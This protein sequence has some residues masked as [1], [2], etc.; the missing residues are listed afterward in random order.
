MP[1]P[2]PIKPLWDNP[3]K[4]VV[5]FEAWVEAMGHYFLLARRR[6]AQGVAV[7]FDEAEKRALALIIGG[8]EIK[9]LFETVA[10]QVIAGDNAVTF[11]VA[12]TASRAALRGRLNETSLVYTLNKMEQGSQAFAAWYPKVMEAAKRIDW[13]NYNLETACKNVLIFNCESDKLR[14]KAIAENL[15]YNDFIRAGIA[16]ENSATK[17]K[18]MGAEGVKSV[19]DEEV[20]RLEDREKKE[21]K[22]CK[23]CGRVA[24]QRGQTCFALK[25]TCHQ[26]SKVGHLK[27]VCRKKKPERVKYLSNSSEGTEEEPVRRVKKKKKKKKKTVPQTDSDSDESVSKINEIQSVKHGE[28]AKEGPWTSLKVNDKEVGFTIDSGVKRNLLNRKDW[29]R[30]AGTTTATQTNKRF[31]PYGM[32]TQL[33][34]HSKATVSLQAKNGAKV[35][36]EVF[37]VESE[38]VD[39]LLG[40]DDGIRLGIIKLCP[41]GQKRAKQIEKEVQQKKNEIAWLRLAKKIE[42][43]EGE[44]FS[45]GRCQ[46]EV[47]HDIQVILARHSQ[48]FQGLGRVKKQEVDIQLK[49]DA[50]PKIQPRR[51]I[52]IH[53]MDKLKKKVEELKREGVIEGPLQGPLEPGSYVSNPV[54]TAKRWSS[55]EIRLNL[56]LSDANA[57]I[58]MSAHPI[59]TPEELRHEFREADTFTSIDANQMFQQWMIAINKRKLFT[60][61]TPWGL[62]RYVRLP[63]GVNCA[64]HECNNNFRAIVEGLEGIVQIQDDVVVYGKGKQHDERLEK[65]LARIEEWGITLRKEKCHWGRPEVLWFGKVYSK[66]G[67]SMDPAK[68][69]VIRKLPPPQSA[70][71]V[72]SFLQMAQF[73]SEFLHPKQDGKGKETNYAELTKPLRD[74]ANAGTA[75]K[76]TIKC[77]EAFERIKELMASDKVL[78][79]FHPERPT[80]VYVDFSDEG[81]SATLAQGREISR[82]DSKQLK[83]VGARVEK[84]KKQWVEWRPVT[85]VS[86][87]LGKA[88]RGYASV[89]GESLAVVYGVWRLR[90]YLWGAEFTVAGDHKPLLAHYNSNKV[91]PHRVTRHKMKLQGFTFQLEWEPGS[92]N[93]TD[94]P[95]RHPLAVDEQL[96]TDREEHC[97][98]DD[99]ENIVSSILLDDMPEAISISKVE[100]EIKRD[101]VLCQVRE[102]ITNRTRCP[103]GTNFAPYKKLYDELVVEQGVVIR[104]QRVVVPQGLIQDCVELAHRGH[105]GPA[106][107]IAALREKVWFPNMKVTV[108][109]FVETCIPCQ[110]AE[111]RTKQPP[112]EIIPLPQ[113]VW[114]TVHADYKGPV[115]G[116]FYLHVV[117]DGYTRF[118]EVDITSSTGGEELMPKMDK[119]WATHGIPAKLISDNGPPYCSHEFEQYCRRMGIKHRPITE[120]HSQSNA[121]AERFMK[122]L[123]RVIHTAGA[124][125]RDPRREVFKFVLNYNSSIHSSTGKAPAELLMK[126]PMK[127]L[128]PG[129]PDKADTRMDKEVRERDKKKKLYNKEQHD[130]RTKAKEQVVQSGD[131][132]LIKQ[133]K[134][135]VKPPWDPQPF[136]VD[137]VSKRRLHLVR[138]DGSKRKRDL[139]DVKV[140]KKRQEKKRMA[141]TRREVEG[142]L[143]FDMEKINNH[144]NNIVD[145]PMEVIPA[146]VVLEVIPPPVAPQP[147]PRH[148]PREQ[149]LGRGAPA[150]LSRAILQ[151]LPQPARGEP[152]QQGGEMIAGPDRLVTT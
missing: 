62:Y 118:A 10:G 147:A 139:G 25:L 84:L 65:L 24:H 82:E 97:C 12:V 34:I 57:D 5:L 121:L 44:R 95:S 138:E 2:T 140:I 7:N 63:S 136:T 23:T 73:N 74:A 130:R 19:K 91:S 68:T 76:W 13:D 89:E 85:H 88:E 28:E 122:R 149:W 14:M 141:R 6:N 137:K 87:S 51:P 150:P 20:K 86:R 49:P 96:E 35:E 127:T 39:S 53:Y 58:V 33:P 38:H 78:E 90:R 54:V 98:G 64:S 116:Q 117:I 71:E 45:G 27:A 113:Q 59:P 69:E 79:H 124:E 55:E 43:E 8:P 151:P 148:I 56:D 120:T 132:A 1:T 135:T 16:I 94:Y 106:A 101:P 30:V 142:D 114:H 41:E 50:S 66:A 40:R 131:R 21:I 18:T 110:A 31:T 105:L 72:R 112:M 83:R 126:R 46:T 4:T 129:L 15:D 145:P 146:P 47:D 11:D 119:I 17:A 77:Q 60:F 128:L 81:V 103:S 133:R 26:C 67:V 48:L 75:F 108:D 93:P 152:P 29:L 125:G 144:W 22:R 42:R 109:M 104:G 52:P 92:Q 99:D 9:S 134:T 102:A 115:G 37:I 61:R 111:K 100:E 80:K 143:D 70:K 36:T 3:E 32:N 107:T 123:V